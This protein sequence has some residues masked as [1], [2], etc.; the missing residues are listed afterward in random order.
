VALVPFLFGKHKAV[1]K[2][3]Q[4]KVLLKVEINPMSFPNAWQQ[5]TKFYGGKS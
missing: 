3:V 5:R 4:G 2:G 1:E